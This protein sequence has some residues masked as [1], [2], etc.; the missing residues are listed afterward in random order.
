MVPLVTIKT[1]DSVNR[2]F[3]WSKLFGSSIKGKVLN[4]IYAIHENA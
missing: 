3:L 4:K 2:S 1:F